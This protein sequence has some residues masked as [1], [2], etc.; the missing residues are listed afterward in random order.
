MFKKRL[1]LKGNPTVTFVIC[2]A[3][4]ALI[5]IFLSVIFA[6]IANAS[7]DPTG[8]LGLFSLTTLIV[9]AAASGFISAKIKKEGA[10][11]FSTL[12][13]LALT[14]IML[15]VC[16][17]MGGGVSLSAFMNYLCYVGVAALSA[18]IGSREG[19]HKRHKR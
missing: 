8:N 10:L 13:A 9:G 4:S 6:F 16:V 18:F 7:G 19:R 12:V 5:I 11:I 14:L 3:I 2:L 1:S 15:L 17:I